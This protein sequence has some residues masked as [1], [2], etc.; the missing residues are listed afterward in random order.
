M[1]STYMMLHMQDLDLEALV[2]QQCMYT[3]ARLM[4]GEGS[5]KS[6]SHGCILYY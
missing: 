4:M 5:T 1:A 2:L 3:H 6:H